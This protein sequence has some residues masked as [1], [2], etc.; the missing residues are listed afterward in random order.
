MR[1]L[2]LTKDV[3]NRLTLSEI[4]VFGDLEARY[5]SPGVSF[6]APVLYEFMTP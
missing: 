5:E 3:C 1:E 6:E 4:I 2:L